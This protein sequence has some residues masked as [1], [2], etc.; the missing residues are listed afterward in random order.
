MKKYIGIINPSDQV[1]DF[2]LESNR[3]DSDSEDEFREQIC[4]QV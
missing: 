4:G 3:S 1:L 2:E